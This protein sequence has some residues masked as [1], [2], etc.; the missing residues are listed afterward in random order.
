M[1]SLKAL[2]TR[3]ASTEN[4]AKITKSMKMVSASKLRGDETRMYAARPF[5][6][7][8]TNAIFPQEYPPPP[9]EEG[10]DKVPHLQDDIDAKKY[11]I[12]TISSD[13]GLCG[14]VNTYNAKT[15]GK[16]TEAGKEFEIVLAGEKARSA[17]ERQVDKSQIQTSMDEIYT[18]K[19]NF[20]QSSAVASRFLARPFDKGFIAFNRYRSAIA[21][22]TCLYHVPSF[23]PDDVSGSTPAS[24]DAADIVPENFKGYELEPE[25]KSEALQNLYEFG[26][27]SAIYGAT[28]ENCAAEQS[29]RMTAMDNAT[30]NAN[31]LIDT[32]SLKYNRARQASIT[33]E[34]T[35][36]I[37]GASAVE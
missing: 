20:T 22:D 19:P 17:I 9:V 26:V 32:L 21:Y 30:N 35:E 16:V 34:L 37:S 23:R 14:G 2:K 7:A 27:A 15:T 29:A 25:M 36:I 18:Y 6:Q 8:V 28:L 33:T 31:E 12:C 5:F 3:I 10:E 13:R 1:A 24:A 4:I 11:A